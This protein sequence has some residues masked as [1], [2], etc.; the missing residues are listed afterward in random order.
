M[1]DLDSTIRRAE[2]PV[3]RELVCGLM[4]RY[5]AELDVDLCF[6]GFERELDELPGCYAEPAGVVLIAELAGSPV[7]CV[8][9]R[10]LELGRCEMK[11]LYL[12]PDARG[13]G[14]GRSL[15]LYAIAHARARGYT[16]MRLD[17]LPSMTSAMALYRS[18][19][20]VPIGPYRVNPVPGAHFLERR[21]E[22]P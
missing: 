5:A 19:G 4:R 2:F 12:S 6:Q 18:L 1:S 13:A 21:L 7:G 10:P 11:R 16:A 8:A 17:T 3:D 14:L 22:A 9:L 15:A 20:F